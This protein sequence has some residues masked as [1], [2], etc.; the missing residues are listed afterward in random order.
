MAAKS[1]D[2]DPEAERS[3]TELDDDQDEPAESLPVEMG[4]VR[5]W[6][7]TG[8]HG[9]SVSGITW[10]GA[11]FEAVLGNQPADVVQVAL[12]RVNRDV[13][14][15]KAQMEANSRKMVRENWPPSAFLLVLGRI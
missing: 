9:K 10:D 8:N 15:M 6:I 4:E 3:G 2:I 5:R 14:A 7:D 1:E 13:A 11:I 12:D